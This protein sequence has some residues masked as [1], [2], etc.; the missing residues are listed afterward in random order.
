[1]ISEISL[2][3]FRSYKNN[4]FK[5]NPGVNIIIGPNA[6]GKTN[7]LEAILVACEGKSYRAG[8]RELIEFKQDN[9]RIELHTTKKDIRIVFLDNTLSKKTYKINNETFSRLSLQKRIPVVLFEPNNLSMLSGPADLR[10]QFLDDL[11]EK[12]KPGY[13]NLRRAYRRTLSQRNNL[14][15]RGDN[16]VM[17]QLFAWDIRLCDQGEQIARYRLELAQ[18]INKRIEKVYKNMSGSKASINFG[19]ETIVPIA[20]YGT[21]LLHKLEDHIK[22]DQE[23]GF[24][25]YGPHREDIAISINNH[26]L[27][28][29]ASRGEVRSMVLAC[30]IIEALLIEEIIGVTPILL[31]DDV[32]SELDVA[33]RDKLTVFL[34][35][36]QVFI[37]TTNADALSKNKANLIDITKP[38][39]RKRKN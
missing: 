10:R 21:T 32:F 13:G 17:A 11:L 31:L 14:L 26:P 30:K 28:V 4:T 24:T 15:K 6:S 37:T 3:H 36:Y 5:F 25:A 8:D 1:M 29:T 2:K 34:K 38:L 9:A 22:E 33:R 27:Q 23:R 20:G 18:E 12:T 39:A 35:N 16:L 7:L 19:Y